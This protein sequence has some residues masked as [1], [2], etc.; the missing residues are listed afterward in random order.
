M[1]PRYKTA[2]KRD[3]ADINGGFVYGMKAMTILLFVLPERHQGR[4]FCLRTVVN[5]FAEKRSI[6]LPFKTPVTL[7]SSV[8]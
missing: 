6:S 5:G 3:K 2:A 8:P 4:N 7:F 1:A